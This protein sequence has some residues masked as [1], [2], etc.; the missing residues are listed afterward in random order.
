MTMK[1]VIAVLPFQQVMTC[2]TVEQ[3]FSRSCVQGVVAFASVKGVIGSSSEES[4]VA[5]S[6]VEG[7]VSK[8]PFERV[9]AASAKESE[10]TLKGLEAFGIA[11]VERRAFGRENHHHLRGGWL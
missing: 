9:I 2:V 8:S 5:F 3:I 7:C 4:I 10:A 11:S 1:C 6:A